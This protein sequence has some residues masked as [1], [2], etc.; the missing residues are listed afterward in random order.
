MKQEDGGRR[1]KAA[2]L[3]M[4]AL[5][6]LV[7]VSVALPD[8]VCRAAPPFRQK[9]ADQVNLMGVE[10]SKNPDKAK[11]V[12]NQGVD[13][14]NSGSRAYN[15]GNVKGADGY[16]QQAA[17][18]WKKACDMGWADGCRGGYDFSRGQYLRHWGQ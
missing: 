4:A 6:T 5:L 12:Y 8:P 11:A 15:A 14:W 9:S 7:A 2:R 18:Y 10:P 16:Y 1:Q 3:W 13:Y 17:R